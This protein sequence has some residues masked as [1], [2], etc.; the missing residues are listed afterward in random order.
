MLLLFGSIHISRQNKLFQTFLE[1]SKITCSKL[2]N[3]LLLITNHKKIL[4]LVFSYIMY[5]LRDKTCLLI[6]LF[7]G[8]SKNV[9]NTTP[10]SQRSSFEELV[11]DIVTAPSRVV[12]MAG[13]Q[14]RY[15]RKNQRPYHASSVCSRQR[16]HCATR[17][18]QYPCSPGYSCRWI[19]TPKCPGR[20][21]AA[22]SW[23]WR[24]VATWDCA[25]LS[26]VLTCRLQFTLVGCYN[27]R[28]W[29]LFIIL[30]P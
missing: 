25:E 19:F 1:Y 26:R 16:Q 6:N 8:I 29:E 20:S 27:D 2:I 5:I 21:H 18:G 24:L 9:S 12:G 15:L 11:S 28:C 10:Q 4:L 3:L 30:F 17:V 14:H 7:S 22:E 13:S 23:P